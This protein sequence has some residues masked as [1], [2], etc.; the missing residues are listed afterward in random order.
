MARLQGYVDRESLPERARASR[1]EILATRKVILG[2]VAWILPHAPEVA[3]R[4]AALGDAVRRTTAIGKDHVQIAACLAVRAIGNGYMWQ[5]HVRSARKAG[6]TPDTLAAIESGAAADGLPA[7][8]ALIIRYCRE[9]QG[10]AEISAA[11]F[12]ALRQR[13]G[14][15]GIMEL[16]M[17]YSYYLTMTTVAKTAGIENETGGGNG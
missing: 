11:T 5:A 14:D 7:D 12:D 2:P 1:D 15:T 3:V 8:A 4:T 10:A 13:F 17:V 16:A 9:L 6:V